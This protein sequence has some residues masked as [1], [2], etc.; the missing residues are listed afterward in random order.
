MNRAQSRPRSDAVRAIPVLGATIKLSLSRYSRIGPYGHTVSRAP[1]SYI[2]LSD[3]VCRVVLLCF[4]ANN[5]NVLFVLM[6]EVV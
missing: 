4:E 1:K 2:A 3:L 6:H 5:Y